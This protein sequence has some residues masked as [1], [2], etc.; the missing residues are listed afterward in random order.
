M[1]SQ[2]KT[3]NEQGATGEMIVMNAEGDTKHYW[4]IHNW[5]EVEAAKETFDVYKRKGFTA[6][7]MIRGKQSKQLQEFDPA[8]GSILFVPLMAGG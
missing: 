3:G 4:N 2:P 6:F 1:K 5:S 7:S 8:A